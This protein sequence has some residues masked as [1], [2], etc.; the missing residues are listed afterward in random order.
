MKLIHILITLCLLLIISGL[1]IGCNS[2]PEGKLID[3]LT[4]SNQSKE[5]ITFEEG[6]V[7]SFVDINNNEVKLIYAKIEQDFTHSRIVETT[8]NDEFLWATDT[9]NYVTFESEKWIIHND[10]IK[11]SLEIADKFCNS[12]AD[13]VSQRNTCFIET[14]FYVMNGDGFNIITNDQNNLESEIIHNKDNL[15]FADSMLISNTLFKNIYYNNNKS[16]VISKPL[17]VIGFAYNDIFYTR[18]L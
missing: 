15:N 3:H 16:L 8:C 17:N 10:S 12:N 9:D 18:K 13:L 5:W 11:I 2:C 14:I 1:F 4:L 7:I 6:E